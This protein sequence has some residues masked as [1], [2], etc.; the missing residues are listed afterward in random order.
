MQVELAAAPPPP[1][2]GFAAA[3]P[4]AVVLLEG[5]PTAAAPSVECRHGTAWFVRRLGVHLLARLTDRPDRSIAE[6]LADAVAET[7]ALHGGR[8]DL[9]DPAKAPAAAVLAARVHGGSLEYLV[10]GAGQRLRLERVE[11]PA[12]VVADRG[13]VGHPVGASPRAAERART[14]FEPLAG[15]HA[16]AVPDGGAGHLLRALV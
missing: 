1:G 15:L 9:A 11:G 8:C 3:T 16:L 14:G 12:L 13:G 6:C 2:L 7:A 5:A 10:F 4:E